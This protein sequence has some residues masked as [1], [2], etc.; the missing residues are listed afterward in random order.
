MSENNERVLTGRLQGWS[1]LSAEQLWLR[2]RSG[3]E[4]DDDAIGTALW[5]A[6]REA[7]THALSTKKKL[8]SV[9]DE[10]IRRYGSEGY[11]VREESKLCFSCDG[12]GEDRYGERC[13]R[14]DGTGKYLQRWLYVHHFEVAGKT[15]SFHSYQEPKVLLEGLGESLDNY[16]TRFTVEEVKQ[17]ALPMTGL[18]RI[19]SYVAAALWKMQF[20]H[21]RYV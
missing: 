3:F 14:C 21:G 6:N 11:R 2:W 9:K 15:Y 18:I 7:K 5:I 4:S 17:L 13:E 20:V 1:K 16:G 10:F 19:L 12:S 8:Y